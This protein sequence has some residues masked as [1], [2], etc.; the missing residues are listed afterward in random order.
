MGRLVCE[1]PKIWGPILDPNYWGSY[2]EDKTGPA[3]CRNSHLVSTVLY[4][5][6]LYY[7]I[8]YY[9][10]L[11]Y[12]IL[13]YTILYYTIL[14]YTILYYTIL[15]YTILYYTILYYTIL[16][17]TIPYYTLETADT[18]KAS[19]GGLGAEHQVP[20][21]VPHFLKGSGLPAKELRGV[22]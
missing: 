15:Y 17:H 11:Y 4:Y 3:V 5:T 12:T 21:Q 18:C 22:L 14:Y 9:T 6:I 10:I 1:F 19:P 7:T 8:L 13:Y 20:P 2:C 16:Y